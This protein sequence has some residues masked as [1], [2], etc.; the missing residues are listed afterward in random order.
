M[1]FSQ[2]RRGGFTTRSNSTKQGDIIEN[3]SCKEKEA[4]EVCKTRKRGQEFAARG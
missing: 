4:E 2:T 3:S 1:I